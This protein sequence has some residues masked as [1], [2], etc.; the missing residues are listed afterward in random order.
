LPRRSSLSV[1]VWIGVAKESFSSGRKMERWRTVGP[2]AEAR[3]RKLRAL[4]ILDLAAMPSQ[5]LKPPHL[6]NSILKPA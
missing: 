1:A 6:L 2:G 4:G 5:P 3:E